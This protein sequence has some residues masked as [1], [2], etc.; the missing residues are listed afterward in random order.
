MAQGTG[1]LVA[2]YATLAA[3]IFAVSA[4]YGFLKRAGDVAALTRG[5]E[6]YAM[7]TGRSMTLL[8]SRIQQATGG[9]L[10]FNEASQAAAIGAAAGLSNEQ[11]T[12]LARVAKNASV[13][14]GR[15]LTDAFNRLTRG[16]I[17]AEPELL[18]ELGIIIRLDKVLK[19][20]QEHL[21]KMQKILLSLKNLKL[22]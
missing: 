7:K 2:A 11:L 1:G 4:A 8:T 18:D 14:L 13:S 3:N 22:L 12:G 6:E 9:I 17:K 15:D 16:A 21:E 20:I 10:A 19:T 5:Q